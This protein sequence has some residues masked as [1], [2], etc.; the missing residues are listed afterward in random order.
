M[1]HSWLKWNCVCDS[2]MYACVCLCVLA[3]YTDSLGVK[4]LAVLVVIMSPKAM[5]SFTVSI[6][7]VCNTCV[8]ACVYMH[9]CVC[10]AWHQPRSYAKLPI[11]EAQSIKTPLTTHLREKKHAHS[12]RRFHAQPTHTHTH[13][14]THILYICTTPP[15]LLL[16]TT[17]GQIHS[18]IK[19]I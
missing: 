17:L 14:H 18:Q 12:Q 10:P 3:S 6:Q 5:S 7:F 19:V 16:L 11:S 15:S 2:L 9:L 8:Y 1:C 13:V 4:Y